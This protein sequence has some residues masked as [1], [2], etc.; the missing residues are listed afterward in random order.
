MSTSKARVQAGGR[1]PAA[2]ELMPEGALAAAMPGKGGTAV[3]AFAPLAAG[4]L[5][6]GIEEANLRAPEAV[7]K[8]GAIPD[9]AL[10]ETQ[11][12][13]IAAYLSTLK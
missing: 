8:G 7:V 10:S 2:V 3:Y 11:A 6:A 9:M 4:A 1:P 5:V 13:Q 12:R